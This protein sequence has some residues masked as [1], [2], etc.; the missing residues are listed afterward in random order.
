MNHIQNNNDIDLVH[1]LKIIWIKKKFILLITSFFAFTSIIY[2]LQ[3]PNIYESKA[4][5]APS[6][7]SDNSS[8]S[9][10]SFIGI[11]DFQS[12]GQITNA[13]E[14]V[15]RIRSR[16]FFEKHF[17]PF[18]EEKNLVAAEKWK[19]NLNTIEYNNKLYDSLNNKW[20]KKPSQYYFF[21]SQYHPL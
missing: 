2:S 6:N 19:K 3:L 17:Q 14:A 21:E 12:S 7:Q 16:D 18:I 20:I 11:S 15:A 5:L 4:I 10:L 1:F 9:A 13:S 8:F